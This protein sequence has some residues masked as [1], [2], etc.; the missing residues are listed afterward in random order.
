MPL[1]GT[2]LL[3]PTKLVRAR[4]AYARPNQGQHAC[5][6]GLGQKPADTPMRQSA[7]VACIAGFSMVGRSL[8]ALATF[9]STDAHG[10]MC[11]TFS[12]GMLS[13]IAC[14]SSDD[15]LPKSPATTEQ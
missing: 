4:F 10:L 11:S 15:L 13:V 1:K 3:Q 9:H 6:D 7:M 8:A 2:A 14:I 12:P 5:G